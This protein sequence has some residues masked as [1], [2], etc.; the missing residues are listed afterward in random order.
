MKSLLLLGDSIRAGYDRSVKRSLEG[1]AN[2]IFPE[3]SHSDL[4]HYYT[5]MGTEAFAKQVL[6]FVAPALGLEE[7]PKYREELYVSKPVGI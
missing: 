5:P 6:S 1:K 7:A 2:V 4:V 3:E